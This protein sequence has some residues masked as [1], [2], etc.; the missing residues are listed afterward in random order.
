VALEELV[1]GCIGALR[2]FWGLTALRDP[3]GA[4]GGPIGPTRALEGL[5]G[6]LEGLVGALWPV[7]GPGGA[8]GGP[9]RGFCGP[10]SLEGSSR[11]LW[12]PIGPRR[13]LKDLMWALEGLLGVLEGLGGTLRGL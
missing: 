11:S 5:L 13:A 1:G 6:V 4:C 7:R 8:S 9:W 10:R 12:V 3:V 2:G